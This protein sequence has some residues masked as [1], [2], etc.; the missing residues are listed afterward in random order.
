MPLSPSRQAMALD[1]T[2]ASCGTRIFGGQPRDPASGPSPPPLMGRLRRDF[3]RPGDLDRRPTLREQQRR[4]LSPP[5]TPHSFCLV[6]AASIA[7]SQ[8]LSR[9][10][11]AFEVVRGVDTSIGGRPARQPGRN[12]RTTKPEPFRCPSCL[13]PAR[14][15]APEEGDDPDMV[16]NKMSKISVD[17]HVHLVA[18]RA[19]TFI[20]PSAT[21]DQEHP[22]LTGSQS[23]KI[24][25][26]LPHGRTRPPR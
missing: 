4:L 22:L 11:T 15:L 24:R 18:L 10:A 26:C 1:V 23:G 6:N 9:P 20:D 8:A 19:R 17:L 16:P 25:A 13:A 7:V 3:Q 12:W 5:F 14:D 2:S 21:G